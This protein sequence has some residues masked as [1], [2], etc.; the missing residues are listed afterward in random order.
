[1]SARAQLRSIHL[2]AATPT[3]VL[4]EANLGDR[5]GRHFCTRASAMSTA[6]DAFLHACM[7]L[8]TAG[9]E[10]RSRGTRWRSQRCRAVSAGSQRR[11]KRRKNADGYCHQLYSSMRQCASRAPIKRAPQRRR[12]RGRR[13]A[14]PSN[15]STHP[16]GRTLYMRFK[17]WLIECVP[18]P[19]EASVSASW[20]VDV[21]Y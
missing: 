18:A 20:Y 16:L 14:T 8:A 1:M 11:L 6:T 3:A 17:Q 4:D 13:R 19:G 2:L 21:L 5:V 12:R 15:A 10:A 9:A 7:A